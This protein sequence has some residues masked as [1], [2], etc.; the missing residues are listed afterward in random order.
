[1]KENKMINDITNNSLIKAIEK[2]KEGAVILMELPSESYFK[3]NSSTIKLLTGNGFEGIYIS[4]NRPFR[5]V[6]SLLNQHGININKLLFVDV[7]T[8]LSKE[9]QKQNPRCI[10]ISQEIDIDELIRAIYTSFPKLKS[11]KR[12]IFIDSLTTI[13]FYK[14]LSETMRLAEFFVRKVKKYELQNLILIFNVAKDLAQKK[15]IKDIASHV[16]EVITVV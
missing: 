15:F 12:F 13:T 11:D 1:M 6:S 14:P 3:S 8:A 5:N 4:F 9:K 16:D 7:A 10:Q 2:H